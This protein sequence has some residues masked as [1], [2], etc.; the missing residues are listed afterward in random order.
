MTRSSP[1]ESDSLSDSEIGG[2]F[3]DAQF[4]FVNFTYF[5][6]NRVS[7]NFTSWEISKC[8]WPHEFIFHPGL[9]G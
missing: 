8:W 2:S 9:I 6:G 4:N 7:L 5:A 1:E 3:K